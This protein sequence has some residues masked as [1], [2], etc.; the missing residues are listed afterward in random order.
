MV[1]VFLRLLNPSRRQLGSG[2][3][4]NA[5]PG[6]FLIDFYIVTINNKPRPLQS[7]FVQ[8]QYT[9]KDNYLNKFGT[10]MTLVV[11][12]QSNIYPSDT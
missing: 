4:S 5:L 9:H 7:N 6:L 8:I 10:Q 3:P 1:F 12:H 2:T 11:H